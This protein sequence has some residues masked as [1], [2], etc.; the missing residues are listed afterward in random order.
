MKYEI[1]QTSKF[2]KELKLAKKRGLDIQL[3]DEIVELLASDKELPIKNRD[4]SLK[5]NYLGYRE[6]HITP[7]W[8]LI[9]KKSENKLVLTL[10]RTG[11]HADLFNM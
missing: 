4:H 9:Y 5:G 8:L 7:D 10:A 2:K 3:L 1:I 6:C 11:S